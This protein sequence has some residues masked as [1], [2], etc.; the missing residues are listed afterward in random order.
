[1]DD[2]EVKRPE[3][4]PKEEATIIS[5]LSDADLEKV[6]AGDATYM[7]ATWPYPVCWKTK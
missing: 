4:T 7:C 2:N 1:M 5:D 6:A 3:E